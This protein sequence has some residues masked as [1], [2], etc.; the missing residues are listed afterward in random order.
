MLDDLDTSGSPGWWLDRLL[1]R[2]QD[3]QERFALLDAYYAGNHRLP[4][5]DERCRPAFRAF[6]RKARTNYCQLITDSVRERLA[7]VGFRT[8]SVDD[9]AADENAET[10]DEP[11][12]A[13]KAAWRIWQANHLDADSNMLHS[14]ALTFS[15]AYVFVG[16]PIDGVPLI[17]IEDPRQVITEQDPLDRRRVRAALKSWVDEVDNR[18][19]AVVYLPQGTHYYQTSARPKLDGETAG[20]TPVDWLPKA[21]D[22]EVEKEPTANTLGVVTVVPFAPNPTISSS[23]LGEFENIIDIQDRINDTV[24]NRLVITKLQAYRQRWAK[25]LVVDDDD[26]QMPFVPGVDLVWTTEDPDVEFGEFQQVDLTPLLAAV[27]DD[28]HA[29]VMLSGLPPHYVA[30]DLVNASADALAAAEARLVSKV[31]DRQQYLGESW[32]QVLRLAFRHLGQ[33]GR[34]GADAEVIWA[35]PERKSEVAVADAAVKKKT[36][37]VPWRQLMEDLSYT[38]TQVNRMESD[39]AGD[40][41]LAESLE[42]PTP[43]AAPAAAAPAPP[44]PPAGPPPAVTNGAV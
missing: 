27:K 41:L 26:D 29:I 1:K 33:P 12:A 44:A 4:E 17:T 7:V 43:P 13:D 38:P 42:N 37:G 9:A 20:R 34:V 36:V 15:E 24:L 8:G 5:G 35:D 28:V 19:H 31:R 10:E 30:G 6:Q 22:W 32:E 25:G 3:R 40:A 21:G 39:R 14:A 23:G 11:V 18:R 2:L 16:P